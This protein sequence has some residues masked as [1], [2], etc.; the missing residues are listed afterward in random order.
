[1]PFRF[2][3]DSESTAPTPQI[4]ADA[5]D[6]EIMMAAIGGTAGT[7]YGKGP[8]GVES[9]CAVTAQ[10][11]PD[12][13]VAVAA[14]V[15]RIGGRRVA[16]GAGN[17]NLSP[18]D[19]TNP[20]VDLIAVDT[21]GTKSVTDG[22]AAVAPVYPTLPTGKVILAAVYRAAND[23]TIQTA[24]ITAK[25]VVI[26]TPPYEDVTWYGATGTGAG[27]DSVGIQAAM[28]AAEIIGA[29]SGRGIV[30]FPA[31]SNKWRVTSQI[32]WKDKVSVYSI[33]STVIQ[34]QGSTLNDGMIIS[35]NTGG[36]N[37]QYNQ[38][39]GIGLEG[40]NVGNNLADYGWRFIEGSGKVDWGTII[41]NF[42]AQCFL[43]SAVRLEGGITNFFMS[44]FRIDHTNEYMVDI[45]RP[46]TANRT[47]DFVEIRDFTFDN[48]SA[49]VP[50][51]GCIRVD[52]GNQ[53]INDAEARVT[54]RNAR[55]ELN[56]GKS[57]TTTDT[58]ALP[59]GTINV[60]DT[61]LFATSGIIAI[62]IN[63]GTTT[64]VSYT[65]KTGTTFTGC[66]G[67]TGTYAS[68]AV[69]AQTISEGVFTLI[70]NPT[71]PGN[72]M[73]HVLQLDNVHVLTPV[74][75]ADTYP[76]I[77]VRQSDG[78]AGQADYTPILTYNCT[79]KTR[80]LVDDG[81]I[82]L[83]TGVNRRLP[84][85][86]YGPFNG[87]PAGNQSQQIMAAPLWLQQIGI[88]STPPTGFHA[89][90]VDSADAVFKSKDSTGKVSV[91]G[92]RVRSVFFD[93]SI[94][95]LDAASGVRMGVPPN[96]VDGIALVN[97]VTSGA[98]F[99]FIMPVDVI[100]G[101]IKVRPIWVPSATTAA[102]TVRW[103][104]NIRVISAADVTAAGTSV[105]WTGASAARTANVEVMEP[106]QDSTGV[107]PV[108][109]DRVRLEIQRVGGDGA[110]TYTGDVY[111][112][113]VRLDYSAN[114]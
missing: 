74:V 103:Q 101:L 83:D 40:G 113:G 102:L 22:T 78:T 1:M 6:F 110:D 73:S 43:K 99:N 57:T 70:Q 96:V 75:V 108:A 111:L 69:V 109:E 63:D 79:P 97:G 39:V 106:G 23:N 3:N 72:K 20:R 41:R 48:A 29:T 56:Y 16:V 54:V 86:V 104:M 52:N 47:I 34:Y 10:G 46:V 42:G 13:T 30:F 81:V 31:C 65:G 61:S 114:N 87:T 77:K 93:G 80:Y 94:L 11:T 71:D 32:V 8:T 85:F 60:A 36:Q 17:V 49:T 25:D 84:Y 44:D 15:V 53:G 92:S 67:G 64:K 24:D 7:G 35:E 98:Y 37:Y 33:R 9:G 19:G 62:D 38:W 91:Y 50:P 105:A 112:I 59:Q 55:V 14:G 51:K 26:P 12:Q 58:Q 100:T 82:V 27:D 4:E 2:I 18:A 66:T 88:P 95:R 45:T 76:L 68:S 28:D 21:A 90:Y 89:F 5:R 107:S